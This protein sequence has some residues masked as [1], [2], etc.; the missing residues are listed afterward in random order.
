MG[1]YSTFLVTQSSF[2]SG[3]ASSFNLAGNTYR[4]NSSQSAESAD[5]RALRSDLLAVGEDFRNA[6]RSVHNDSP[7][8]MVIDFK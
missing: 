4:Y 5:E 7:S 3:A 1:E 2:L 8:Q 6:I